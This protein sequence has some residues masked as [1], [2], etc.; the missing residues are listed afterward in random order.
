MVW[1]ETI[2]TDMILK[3]FELEDR[4]GLIGVRGNVII[5]RDGKLPTQVF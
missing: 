5:K 4:N 3:D 2:K 1:I